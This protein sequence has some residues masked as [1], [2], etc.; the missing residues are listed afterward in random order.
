MEVFAPEIFLECPRLM[1]EPL[2]AHHASLIYNELLNPRLYKYIPDTPPNSLQELEKKYARL[3][4]RKSPD[5]Q[6]LWLNWVASLRN[7]QKYVGTFQATIYANQTA[8]IAYI[9]FAQFWRRGYGGEASQRLLRHL[10]VDYKVRTIS[11]NMD[12]RNLASIRL[13]ESLGFQRVSL[14]QNAD[15]FK[16]CR[17]DEYRYEITKDRF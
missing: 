5:E 6:E 14:I 8:E 1:L 4:S 9:V 12:T 16:G 7:Q 3:E 15:Y 17:S 10:F 11:A 2:L 13:V